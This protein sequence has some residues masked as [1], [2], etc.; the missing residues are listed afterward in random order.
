[1]TTAIKTKI[2]IFKLLTW[3]EECGIYV[4]QEIREMRIDLHGSRIICALIHD[5]EYGTCVM[6]RVACI[7]HTRFGIHL[8]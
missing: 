1:M 3:F 5:G 4:S 8:D 7:L 6:Q 2:A